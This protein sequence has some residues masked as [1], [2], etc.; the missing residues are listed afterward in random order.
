MNTRSPAIAAED[1][2]GP[3]VLK[4]QRSAGCSGNCTEATPSKAGPP[5]NIGQSTAAGDPLFAAATSTKP[6]TATV[7]LSSV[8]RLRMTNTKPSTSNNPTAKAQKILAPDHF[9]LTFG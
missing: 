3:W 5:R 8:P 9:M 1:F 4:D 7:R 2:T 6:C